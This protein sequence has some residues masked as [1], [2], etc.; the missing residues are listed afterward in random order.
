M[1]RN[2]LQKAEYLKSQIEQAMRVL[3]AS[4][5]SQ[6]QATGCATLKM[7]ECPPENVFSLPKRCYDASHKDA[8]F[9]LPANHIDGEIPHQII[10]RAICGHG[11]LRCNIGCLTKETF[12][13]LQTTKNC[14]LQF[15]EK[16]AE[17][18]NL[19]H[20][21]YSAQGQKKTFH[22]QCHDRL[23]FT[24]AKCRDSAKCKRY[25]PIN[26]DPNDFISPSQKHVS[27]S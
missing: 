24:V 7:R 21:L 1:E 26:K 2:V 10:K 19:K 23:N 15:A 3:G 13:A 17:E 18:L 27:N 20:S 9:L 8:A 12:S 14:I 4:K 25:H 11:L 22:A 16:C 5:M 6:V